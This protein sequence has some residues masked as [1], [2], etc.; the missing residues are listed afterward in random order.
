M[1]YKYLLR[2][3]SVY[4]YPHFARSSSTH[5]LYF[6]KAH[7]ENLSGTFVNKV[8]AFVLRGRKYGKTGIKKTQTDH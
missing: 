2:T 4:R 3:V 6:P 8:C 5:F 7:S 1:I